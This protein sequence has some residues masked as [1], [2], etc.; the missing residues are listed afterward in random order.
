MKNH[1]WPLERRKMC[2][3]HFTHNDLFFLFVFFNVKWEKE[4]WSNNFWNGG[5]RRVSERKGQSR[6]EKTKRPSS[7]QDRGDNQEGGSFL[8]LCCRGAP[9]TVEELLVCWD[10][11]GQRE[12]QHTSFCYCVG[13]RREGW[14]NNLDGLG[15]I[16]EK[17]RNRQKRHT[18]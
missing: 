15:L 11:E 18:L 9:G 17:E 7:C 5:R 12:R 4:F 13:G 6:D 16:K 2:E 14:R 1:K 10:R 3:W 8:S